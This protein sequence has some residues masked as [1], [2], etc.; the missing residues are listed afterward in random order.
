ANVLGETPRLNAELGQ[1]GRLLLGLG[2]QDEEACAADSGADSTCT[3]AEVIRQALVN[4]EL[5]CL[6]INGHTAPEAALSR[7][8]PDIA[9]LLTKESVPLLA[10]TLDGMG[11]LPSVYQ[12]LRRQVPR[13][14]VT[15]N[16]PATLTAPPPSLSAP[17]G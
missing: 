2:T 16:A 8:S 12:V 11:D 10:M 3:E 14:T 13:V 6:F 17:R 4:G 15:L 9:S 7:V 5:V 1:R